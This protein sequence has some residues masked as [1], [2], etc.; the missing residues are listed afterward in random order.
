MDERDDTNIAEPDEVSE[1]VL[2]ILKKEKELTVEQLVNE[3]ISQKGFRKHEATRSIYRL[4]GVGKIDIID[5]EPPENAL[6]FLFSSRATWFWL[7]ALTVLLTDIS[8]YILPQA[9]PFEYVRYFLGSL[10][11]LFL[12]GASLVELLYPKGDELSQLERFALSIG[13]SL[14]VVPLVGL[15]LNYTPLGIRLDPIVASLSLLT[16]LFSLGAVFRK[17]SHHISTF[18]GET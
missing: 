6:K 13:L 16:T 14:A 12:P 17:Y 5:P 4:R 8:I 9:P 1:A 18:K 10:F 15:V 3:A 11:V 7:L 2:S